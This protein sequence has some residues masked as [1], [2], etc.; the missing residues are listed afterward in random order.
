MSSSVAYVESEGL[1][2]QD[3]ISLSTRMIG[4]A[5]AVAAS[6]RPPGPL[7]SSS[8]SSRLSAL[9]G[10]ASS[11]AAKAAPGARSDAASA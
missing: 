8:L 4:D 9:S 2:A 11:E 10:A 6:E 7:A 3:A 5:P 1:L